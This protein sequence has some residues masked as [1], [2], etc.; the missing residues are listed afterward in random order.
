[1]FLFLKCF[2]NIIAYFI[3]EIHKDKLKYNLNKL[4][5]KQKHELIRIYLGKDAKSHLTK[6]QYIVA[7]K[8][9]RKFDETG[10]V[11]D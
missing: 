7:E 10:T 11:N 8:L 4:T 9:S 6:D 1:M 5:V 2:K 3:F